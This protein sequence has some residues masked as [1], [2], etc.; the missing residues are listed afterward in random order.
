MAIGVA[1]C[2]NLVPGTRRQADQ[3]NYDWIARYRAMTGY[4]KAAG[5][6]AAADVIVPRSSAVLGTFTHRGHA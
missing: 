6:V 4:G 2:L 5:Q 1:R 3:L